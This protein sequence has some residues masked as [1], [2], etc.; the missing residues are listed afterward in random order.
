[1]IAHDRR[2]HGRSEQT[3]DVNDLDTYV[4]D[5]AALFEA[6]DVRDAVMAGH[7]TGG[8]EV[9]R[10]IGLHGTEHVAKAVFV[11]TIA[12]LMLKTVSNPEGTPIEVFDGL[13]ASTR[14]NRPQFFR[15]LSLPSYGHKCPGAQ[16]SEGVRDSLWL[17]GMV[18]GITG[19]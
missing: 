11:S 9:C 5:L 16:V 6:L 4:D 18:A 2:G 14:D 15:D 10:F 1:M 13:R 3:W 8:G 12:P 19:A 7:S 17:K